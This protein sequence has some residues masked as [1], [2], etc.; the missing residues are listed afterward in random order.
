M[1]KNLDVF[2]FWL[3]SLKSE[4]RQDIQAFVFLG[5]FY[6]LREGTKSDPAA[7]IQYPD[8]PAMLIAERIFRDARG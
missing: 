3:V 5:K 1:L 7:T 4:K 2:L 8:I 6:V